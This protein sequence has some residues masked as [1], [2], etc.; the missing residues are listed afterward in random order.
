MYWSAAVKTGEEE[1]PARAHIYSRDLPAA[2]PARQEVSD[3]SNLSA[4]GHTMFYV[5]SRFIDPAMPEGVAHV[6]RRDL[7]TGQNEV[8][9]EARVGEQGRLVDL[10]SSGQ[11]VAFIVRTVSPQDETQTRSTLTLRTAD[12][13]LT[14]IVGDNIPF[15]YPVL[16][17]DVL[18]WDGGDNGG[19]WIFDRHRRVVVKLG[20]LPGRAEVNAAG[21][22]IAWRKKTQWRTATLNRP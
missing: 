2:E 14:D 9:Y 16:T 8:V 20:S 17:P 7:R 12:G 19:Q 22:H 15:L 3:A 18:G 1:R 13:T 21:P 5:K 6:H 11:D 10:A 4:D